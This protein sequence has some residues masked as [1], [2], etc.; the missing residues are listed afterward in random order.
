[1]PDK[2][3]DLVLVVAFVLLALSDSILASYLVLRWLIYG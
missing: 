2:L 1:M 3:S